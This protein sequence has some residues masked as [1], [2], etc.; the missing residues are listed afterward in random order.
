[1]KIRDTS[2]HSIRIGR[3]PNGCRLCVKGSKL[4]LLV[5][6]LCTSRC[7]YCPLSDVK[8]NRNVTVAN[9]WWISEDK[10]IIEEA[11]LCNSLGAG[12]TGGDPLI[13]L[14]RTVRYIKM[15]KKEFGK[16][17]HIH[18]YTP[19]NLAT[20]ERLKKLYDAGLDEIRFH[21]PEKKY[22]RMIKNALEFDWDIGCEIPVIPGKKK[23]IIEFIDYID[24]I[25]V[26]FLNLNE[27]EISET[28]VGEMRK[29]GF[30]P[31]NDIS[32]A[33]KGSDKLAKELLKYCSKNNSLRVHYCTVKLKDGIQ[34]ANRLKRRAKNVSRDYDIVTKEGLLIR[35][36]IYLWDIYPTFGYNKKLKGMKNREKTVI[37]SKLKKI[38]KTIKDK[39]D[40]PEELIELDERK[41]RILT[42]GWIVKEIADDLK[43][44]GLKPAIVEEYPTWDGLCVDLEFL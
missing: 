5:T 17:F 7:W 10:D 14:D 9:E 31:K 21:C 44:M 20:K 22:W 35:G 29:R 42:G 41:L 19:G 2:Y 34:L 4:V 24:S 8:R 26:D 40:I 30:V 36:A 16:D 38:I 39:F 43:L 15:L 25:G 28:N 32:Y 33:V 27:L 6:G 11:K 12:F 18:L 3:L 23:E 13:V 37:L 1:M